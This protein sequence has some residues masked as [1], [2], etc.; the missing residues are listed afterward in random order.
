[1]D[2]KTAYQICEH[3]YAAAKWLLDYIRNHNLQFTQEDRPEIFKFHMDRI[4][5]LFDELEQPL[6][7]DPIIPRLEVDFRKGTLTKK[8]PP[9]KL[10][11][12]PIGGVPRALIRQRSSSSQGANED[13]L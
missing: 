13:R 4:D 5:A 3:T 6:T 12:Y 1:L 9:D 11:V 8:R 10:P 2:D 7:H